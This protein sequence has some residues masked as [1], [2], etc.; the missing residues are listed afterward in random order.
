MVAD[1]TYSPDL[2]IDE[3][4]DVVTVREIERGDVITVPLHMLGRVWGKYSGHTLRVPI[5]VE[6]YQRW[7]SRL[8]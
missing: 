7:F 8:P 6:Q 1:R 2:E 3:N 5:T 4:G